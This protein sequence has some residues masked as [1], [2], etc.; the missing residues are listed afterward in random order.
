MLCGRKGQSSKAKFPRRINRAAKTGSVRETQA[1]IYEANVTLCKIV[2]V[3]RLINSTGHGEC[4]DRLHPSPRILHD[5]IIPRL[6]L[7]EQDS[8]RTGGDLLFLHAGNTFLA[9]LIAQDSAIGSG[10]R[11]KGSDDDQLPGLV[12]YTR[13]PSTPLSPENTILKPNSRTLNLL[14][15][16]RKV[17]KA[18]RKTSVLQ[19]LFS[20]HSK[21]SNALRKGC[22]RRTKVKSQC[23]RVYLREALA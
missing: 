17:P 14:S 3:L 8:N 2:L 20:N 13:T 18:L 6:P 5:S 23:H 22:L 19:L 7:D 15:P 1:R 16:S 12:Y 11:G 21:T 10:D 9:A 4:Q